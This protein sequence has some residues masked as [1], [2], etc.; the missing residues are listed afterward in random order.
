MS[1]ALDGRSQEGCSCIK[2][3]DCFEKEHKD[4][5]TNRFKDDVSLK[6]K[7]PFSL[8]SLEV[9]PDPTGLP[10]SSRVGDELL[11]FQFYHSSIPMN[12]N[13]KRRKTEFK[14]VNLFIKKFHF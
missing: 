14:N 3:P 13:G 6:E 1:R 12:F 10:L 8:R 5:R 7:L 4:Q 2:N 11:I 9:S